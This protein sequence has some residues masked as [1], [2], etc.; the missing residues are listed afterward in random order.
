MSEPG[1]Q[2]TRQWLAHRVP[3]VVNEF[4]E[5]RPVGPHGVDDLV[6]GRCRRPHGEPGQ[7]VDVDGADAVLA[8]AA[9]GEHRH[10]AQQPGDV[11]DQDAVTAEQDGGSQHGVGQA[12]ISQGQLDRGLAPEVRIGRVGAGMRDRHVHDPAHARLGG[13]L[14]QHARLRHRGLVADVPVGKTHPVGVE[15]RPGAAQRFRQ[16]RGIGEIQRPGL[17]GGARGSAA[18]MA[19]ERA[20]AAPRRL[21]FAGDGRARVAERPGDD[22]EVPSRLGGHNPSL[23]ISAVR[24]PPSGASRI[25]VACWSP[26]VDPWLTI[27]MGLPS[28]AACRT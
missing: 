25:A 21:Q 16:A 17:D 19:G 13:R 5:G 11:V 12:E 14:E 27:T 4:E 28:L 26:R 7:V 6:L 20:D 22:V 23:V 24:F 2:I 10:P 8:G 18:R 15:Q 1:T 9:H 3:D